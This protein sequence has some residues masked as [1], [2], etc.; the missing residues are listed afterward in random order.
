MDQEEKMRKSKVKSKKS[1]KGSDKILIR[2]IHY[3]FFFLIVSSENDATDLK[4]LY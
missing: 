4:I 1:M 3:L 2:S